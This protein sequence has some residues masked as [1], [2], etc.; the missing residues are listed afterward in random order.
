MKN[1]TKILTTVVLCAAVFAST[2]RTD[3][4]GGNAAFWPDDEANIAAYPANI[5]NHS[6]VQVT[7]MG[8][9]AVD[10]HTDPQGSVSMVFGHGDHNWSFGYADSNNRDTWFNLGWGN[11]DNMGI[12][13]AMTAES[14]SDGTTTDDGFAI[15][16]GNSNVWGGN[17]GFHFT[18]G[19][20]V[21][22]ATTTPWSD[23]G[24]K[25]N[26]AKSGCDCWVFSNMVAELESPD[27][28][29]M[30]LDLDFWGNIGE[31]AATVVY[32]MG[33]E[34]DGSNTGGITQTA[35]LGIEADITSN[36]TL[37]GG[38]NWEYTLTDDTTDSDLSGGSAYTWHTG[39]GLNF[40]PFTAD[41]DLGTNFWSNPWGY[42][43]GS[44][45]DQTWGNVTMTYNF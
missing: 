21:S 17:L 31:G 20:A 7:N 37:R 42:V 23:N 33:M 3:A 32:A 30:S 22:G 14:S 27:V 25:I 28:G 39:A 16:Y 45:D 44:D 35:N 18:D 43:S 9:G 1:V 34:Y 36:V 40:G 5:N 38:M 13:I 41:F 11:G 19:E 6:F 12:N 2:Q 26:F 24:I 4:L 15:S 29:D 8:N 10:G